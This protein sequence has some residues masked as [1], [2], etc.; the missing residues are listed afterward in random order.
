MKLNEV[1][2]S[3]YRKTD[4]IAY[5]FTER[6]VRDPDFSPGEL[7]YTRP[8][9]SAPGMD[10][11]SQPSSSVPTPT[12]ANV[13]AI[14]PTSAPATA[15]Q[16]NPALLNVVRRFGLPQGNDT[17]KD[18]HFMTLLVVD[19]PA[20]SFGGFTG[21]GGAS[22]PTQ[23]FKA[24]GSNGKARLSQED[25]LYNS[26]YAVE[27]L[28]FCY[29]QK[30]TTHSM[31]AL[32]KFKKNFSSKS[33]CSTHALSSQPAWVEVNP[34]QPNAERFFLS[35]AGKIALWLRD[36]AKTHNF[37]NAAYMKQDQVREVGL[38]LLHVY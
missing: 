7:S 8:P 4:N 28:K 25:T 13:S 6:F 11:T 36:G 10:S 27:L 15:S 14:Q 34:G 24:A 23:P 2:T 29:T 35:Y 20:H 17:I 38:T 18:G 33:D 22:T 5:R 3:P 37:L 21:K 30:D 12:N 32:R 19:F 26:K 31:S 9:A 1:Y 16:T